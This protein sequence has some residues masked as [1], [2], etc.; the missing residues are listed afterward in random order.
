MRRTQLQ[1]L[2]AVLAL[3]FVGP[4]LTGEGV[5]TAS[6]KST[7]AKGSSKAKGKRGKRRRRRRSLTT[8]HAVGESR[9]RSKPL[10]KPSGELWIYS[11]NFREETRVQL[12]DDDGNF[13]EEAL[14]AL[15]HQFR[16]KRTK[17]ERAV[18]PRLYEMLSRIQDH[19]D[20]KRILLVSGFRFQRNEG[21]RH[22]H[23]SAMDIRIPGVPLRKLRAY[24]ASLDKGGM[25]IG[26]Y[27]RAHFVHVDFRA[28]GE[29]SYRWVDRSR[30][31]Q[32]G[33][34]GKRRSRRFH[35]HRQPNS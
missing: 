10:E 33:N 31:G 11:E 5:S 1:V 12:Y 26:F 32:G 27:P 16:C 14:A 13:D 9:L 35:R 25:G 24:A 8:G 2:I 17:E 23:A 19:F 22:Y 18:D 7:A 15:D 20:G 28:P 21:S 3:L 6:A 34:K 29:R 4:A 30:P